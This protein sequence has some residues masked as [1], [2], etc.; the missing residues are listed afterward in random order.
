MPPLASICMIDK[1]IGK[2]ENNEEI[3]STS[4][5]TSKIICRPMMN[6][7]MNMVFHSGNEILTY[8]KIGY[9]THCPF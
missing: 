4:N 7:N 2:Y 6:N 8:N 9:K 1:T 5:K 3:N